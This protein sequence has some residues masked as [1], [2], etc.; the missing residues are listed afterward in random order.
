MSADLLREIADRH[1]EWNTPETLTAAICGDLRL[2]A[3]QREALFGL[4]LERC[5][6][7]ERGRVRQVEQ[8][9][10]RVGRVADPTG[11]RSALLVETFATGDGRRVAWG[12]ATAADHEARIAMLSALRDGIDATLTRHLDALDAIRA[13]GAS[14]LN[15]LELAVAA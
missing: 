6:Q 4:V 7:W 11:A 12:E 15:D 9:V 2:N 8:T 1:A 13:A 10:S 3:R 14:C 5:Q